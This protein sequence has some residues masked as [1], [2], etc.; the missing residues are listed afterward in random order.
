MREVNRNE[1]GTL[2]QEGRDV[3]PMVG[4]WTKRDPGAVGNAHFTTHFLAT[5]SFNSPGDPHLTEDAT[6]AH[7]V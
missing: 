4:L 3:A 5:P 2:M 7:N 1:G 6:K